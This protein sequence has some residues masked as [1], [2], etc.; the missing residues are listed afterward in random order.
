[1]EPGGGSGA[2]RWWHRA[3]RPGVSGR[4]LGTVLV[5]LLL[6]TAVSVGI[7][8]ERQQ[9]LDDA[10]DV[11]RSMDELD[12]LL[13]L[14]SAM[15][16]ERLAEEVSRPVRRPPDE[17]LERTGFGTRIAQEPQS[18]VASTDAAFDAVP[19][20]V[21]PFAEADLDELRSRRP[22]SADSP[23]LIA[24]RWDQLHVLLESQV[25]EELSGVRSTAV[26]LAEPELELG[27]EPEPEQ[28]VAG[29][30]RR[31][32]GEPPTVERRCEPGLEEGAI[33]GRRLGFEEVAPLLLQV[34]HRGGLQCREAG[35]HGIS[36]QPFSVLELA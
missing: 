19:E 4:V 23:A 3:T 10:R 26:R 7:T 12:T 18:F 34:R 15:F 33:V 27:P 6:L 36:H 20:R 32:D 24:S 8:V 28:L 35:K 22:S 17:L 21:R 31:R 5:P 29:R 16:A 1:M 25:A 30:G 9:D 13:E 2:Q 14:R 11:A